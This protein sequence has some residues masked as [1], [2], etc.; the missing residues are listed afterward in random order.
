M[1]KHRK[2][3]VL[4]CR[5]REK[6]CEDVQMCHI[7]HT[8]L[9]SR[10][11][12]MMEFR[13]LQFLYWKVTLGHS[14]ELFLL[15]FIMKVRQAPGS[16]VQAIRFFYQELQLFEHRAYERH[17]AAVKASI[18]TYLWVEELRSVRRCYCCKLSNHIHSV[19]LSFKRDSVW[20]TQQVAIF[21][22]VKN[23]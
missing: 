18:C 4:Q 17:A 23:W 16:T 12:L 10:L 6:L 7:L 15:V 9:I 5:C 13:I 1:I 2:Y 21:R 19:T 22:W 8:F 20:C 11:D 3:A 14:N